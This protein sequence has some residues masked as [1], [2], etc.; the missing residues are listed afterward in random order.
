MHLQPIHTHLHPLFLFFLVQA[1]GKGEK[2]GTKRDRGPQVRARSTNTQ[3]R[4]PRKILG[5]K[6]NFVY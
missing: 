2:E 4:S 1:P 5:G 6:K 3:S